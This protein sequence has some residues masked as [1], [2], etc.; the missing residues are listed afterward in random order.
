M[1]VCFTKN[2]F[3]LARFL[4]SSFVCNNLAGSIDQKTVSIVPFL[5]SKVPF[6]VFIVR[7]PGVRG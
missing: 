6:L 7:G 1:F 3:F 2:R 5:V 4:R